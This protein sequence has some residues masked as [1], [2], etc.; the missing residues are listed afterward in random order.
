MHSQILTIIFLRITYALDDR[1]DAASKQQLFYKGTSTL[2]RAT[3]RSTAPQGRTAKVAPC[4]KFVCMLH[5]LGYDMPFDAV[6]SKNSIGKLSVP[7]KE[8][9]RHMMSK[10]FKIVSASLRKKSDK[11]HRS[12]STVFV[13]WRRS[14]KNSFLMWMRSHWRHMPSNFCRMAKLQCVAFCRAA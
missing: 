1:Q 9:V 7:S 10:G 11:V 8:A 4:H 14:A 2:C 5:W 3:H 6:R 12:R 13:T